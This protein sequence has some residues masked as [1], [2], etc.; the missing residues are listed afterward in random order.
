MTV[1]AKVQC[2]CLGWVRLR[3]QPDK[4]N[5]KHEYGWC[6]HTH[7]GGCGRKIELERNGGYGARVIGKCN[8]QQRPVDV[9]FQQ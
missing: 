3:I 6:L 5:P 7:N 8:G 1:V 9:E 2:I 4:E